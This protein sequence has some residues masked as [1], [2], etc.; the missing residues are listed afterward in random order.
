MTNM[1]IRIRDRASGKALYEARA[2]IATRE[3]TKAASDDAVSSALPGRCL[4]ASSSSI[5]ALI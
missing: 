5:A 3:G 4:N 1:E 2:R